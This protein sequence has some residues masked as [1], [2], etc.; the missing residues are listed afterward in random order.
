MQGKITESC[1]PTIWLD[2]T[3]SRLMNDPPPSSPILMLDALPAATLPIYPGLGQAQEYAGLHITMA[4]FCLVAWCK[5]NGDITGN[6][7]AALIKLTMA[8]I[9]HHYVC[10]VVRI[11]FLSLTYCG[12][13]AAHPLP[14]NRHHW[15]NGDCL[16]GKRENYQVCSV[17]YC[18]QQLYT[19]QCTHI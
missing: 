6:S 9:L 11:K 2:A 17:Q 8:H 7:I 18:A 13:L 15:S 10:Y 16:E 12:K 5:Y 3:P 1:T 4:W 14:S 19:V